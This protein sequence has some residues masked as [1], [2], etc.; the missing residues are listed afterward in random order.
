MDHFELSENP[1]RGI[2]I[3][4]RGII[5]VVP[6]LTLGHYINQG[7]EDKI[8]RITEYNTSIQSEKMLA[9]VT[10]KE[11]NDDMQFGLLTPEKAQQGV[12]AL[13]TIKK[14]V[15]IDKNILEDVINLTLMAL[16]R[17]YPKITKEAL[18]EYVD[19]NSLAKLLL[20]I[21]NQD[22]ELKKLPT[23]QIKKIDRKKQK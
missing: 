12:E 1:V 15:G 8:I 7:A 4:L 9:A 11:V 6:T 10:L 16:K 2:E 19:M 23:P 17:N 3:E 13:K 21:Q 22:D 18:Y 5:L 14:E 20:L